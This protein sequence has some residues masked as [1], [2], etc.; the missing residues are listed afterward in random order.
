M[1]DACTG[2]AKDGRFLLLQPPYQDLGLTP[3][4]ALPI[5]QCAVPG[6]PDS[7]PEECK[8]TFQWSEWLRRYMHLPPQVYDPK[9]VVPDNLSQYPQ[10]FQGTLHAAIWQSGMHFHR[11]PFVAPHNGVSVGYT[12]QEALC[13]DASPH[14]CAQGFYLGNWNAKTKGV[15]YVT[16]MGGAFGPHTLGTHPPAPCKYN[17]FPPPGMT[18]WCLYEG[19][20][21]DARQSLP[22]Y[23]GQ[24]MQT[25]QTI[26]VPV[27]AGLSD[28]RNVSVTA[29]KLDSSGKRVVATK[30][31]PF[32][33]HSP[34]KP[35]PAMATGDCYPAHVGIFPREVADDSSRVRIKCTLCYPGEE[36]VL[37]WCYYT[38]RP[39]EIEV[40]PS[41]C[42]PIYSLGTVLSI[43]ARL[44]KGKDFDY[45]PYVLVMQ[46]GEYDLH[47]NWSMA[48]PCV[49]FAAAPGAKRSEVVLR[50]LHA[51]GEAKG[52][53]FWCRGDKL[54]FE[55]V[56]ITTTSPDLV[57][58]LKGE[59]TEMKVE[60]NDCVIDPEINMLFAGNGVSAR[61]IGCELSSNP[62]QWIDAQADATCDFKTPAALA[63]LGKVPPNKQYPAIDWQTR[64]GAPHGLAPAA[65]KFEYQ[66]MPAME[67]RFETNGEL[68]INGQSQGGRWGIGGGHV[69]CDYP[70]WNW[71][72]GQYMLAA[73]GRNCSIGAVK[74][75]I[76]TFLA[77]ASLTRT[78]DPVADVPPAHAH[79]PPVAPSASAPAPAP[80]GGG[81]TPQG[82]QS[83][84]QPQQQQQQ[85]QQQ[86]PPKKDSQS[87]ACCVV[88]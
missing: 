38:P 53:A 27:P 47:C 3:P 88:M 55:G 40:R 2:K 42:P 68:S 14:P 4:G 66:G 69:W 29:E 8:L 11:F 51:E 20:C 62:C 77:S 45:D 56:T 6:L 52:T 85:Q 7:V 71:L 86:A 12:T 30:D 22:G 72:E 75:Y 34:L 18:L 87:S 31:V 21:S 10:L 15:P 79:D 1:A 32:W 78:S 63:L 28:V 17:V 59:G 39:C 33:L 16:N 44:Q 26:Y 24:D 80:A 73:F 46:P 37:E 76:Q 70:M 57:L 81:G 25:E 35:V 84:S 82:T 58:G 23:T 65:Y 5:G 36:D 13:A 54:L 64:A 83:S 48:L 61:L 60:L 49:R 67:W 41:P 19:E 9:L 50:M 74:Y 43:L